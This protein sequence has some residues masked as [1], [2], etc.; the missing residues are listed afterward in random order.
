MSNCDGNAANGC[1]LPLDTN[2][3]CTS[4]ALGGTVSGDAA[5]ST[6]TINGNG[7]RRF[8]FHVTENDTGISTNDL[9]VRFTLNESPG[10][11]YALEAGCDG[12]SVHTSNSG[13]PATVTLRWDEL[14]GFPLPT[15]ESGRDVFVNVVYLNGSACGQ[16]TLQAQGNVNGGPVTCSAK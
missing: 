11:D 4:A 12:C 2:P 3:S 9:S 14:S 15:S 6:L 7:E 13:T 8:F 1:E 10:V 5:S 16:W